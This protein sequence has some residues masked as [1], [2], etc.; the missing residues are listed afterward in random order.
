M[1]SSFVIDKV[2]LIYFRMALCFYGSTA[3]VLSSSS[4]IPFPFEGNRALL[5]YC[6]VNY[7]L[8]LF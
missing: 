8:V 1:K 6:T 3:L 2:L 7:M 5:W 4:S